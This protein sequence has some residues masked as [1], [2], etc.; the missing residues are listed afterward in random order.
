[1]DYY[2]ISKWNRS[3]RLYENVMYCK[4]KKSADFLLNIMKDSYLMTIEHKEPCS[5]PLFTIE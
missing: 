5:T 4:D 2:I 3:S 1:M